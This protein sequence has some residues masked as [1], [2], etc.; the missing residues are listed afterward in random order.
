MDQ[1]AIERA[2]EL[3]RRCNAICAELDAINEKI[4]I[5]VRE[6]RAQINRSEIRAVEDEAACPDQP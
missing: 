5:A 1:D 6:K 2:K 4:K 3:M